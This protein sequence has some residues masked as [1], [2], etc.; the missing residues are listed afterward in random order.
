MIEESVLRARKAQAE[1][2]RRP[3]KIRLSALKAVRKRL[4]TSGEALCQTMW[5]ELGKPWG[6]TF[7]AEIIADADLIATWCK[8]A[9]RLLS[10]RKVA[11]DPLS[12]A[13][14]DVRVTLAPKGV[15]ALVTPWNMP[16]AIPLRTIVPALLSGNAVIWKP[17]E[18]CLETSRQVRGL[19]EGLV[20][21]DLLQLFLGDGRLGAAIVSQPVDHI[22]FT[23][24]VATGREIEQ[25]AAQTGATVSL[26]LGGKDA[27]IVL[28]DAPFERTVEGL[29][30]G[31]FNMSGQ[32][33]SS[34]ERVI[35]TRGI[36][37]RLIDA[38]VARTRE[39]RFGPELGIDTTDV[40]PLAS[41]KQALIVESHVEDAKR[42]GARVLTGG[43][44][45]GRY[46]A[47]TVLVDVP[48]NA[49]VWT[50]ETFGPLLPI[51]VVETEND[52]LRV[53]NESRYGLAASVWTSNL[54]KG[55]AFLAE[56][57][58]G[59]AMVN[60]AC[61]SGALPMAA[62]TGIKDSGHGVTSSEFALYEL[63]RPRTL[64]V[65]KGRAPREL[66]WY[67]FTPGFRAL[68]L[69]LARLLRGEISAL[70]QVI[71]GFISRWK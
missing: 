4:L 53:A 61:F 64:V 30:W 52:A 2:A 65:D 34:I 28:D 7:T 49:L 35:V 8:H 47:P 48:L 58:T 33:C 40:G 27:A 22:C 66:W 29:V 37:Q 55:R 54:D 71:R 43:T 63:T 15:V 36:A 50:D 67:P 17:S 19:F 9:P 21:P 68:G 38:L 14:K 51:V 12:Y 26:E 57:K 45:D 59:V 25:R 31:A 39:V 60:N 13:G 6:D 10:P 23:G 46:F 42:R 70:P 5:T 3:L 62:W 24:S 16:V 20:P 69:A 41:E 56:L 18:L 1:W 32:N 11:L 44:R